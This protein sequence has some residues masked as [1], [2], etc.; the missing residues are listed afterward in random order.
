[1][2]I[3]GGKGFTALRAAERFTVLGQLTWLCRYQAV[4]EGLGLNPD[5]TIEADHEGRQI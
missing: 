3:V 2:P 5:E 1:L 4:I